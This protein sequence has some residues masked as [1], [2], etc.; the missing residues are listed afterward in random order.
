MILSGCFRH[1]AKEFSPTRGLLCDEVTITGTV[2]HIGRLDGVWFNGVQAPARFVRN[3]PPDGP[4]EIDANVPI[5]ATTG[6]I[7]V[8]IS[9][10]AGIVL[11]VLG[12]DHTFDEPF[13]VVGSPPAP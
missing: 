10:D 12:T 11:G 2:Y 13:V 8:K 1:T 3:P 5:G 6:P 4:L 9:T 7:R